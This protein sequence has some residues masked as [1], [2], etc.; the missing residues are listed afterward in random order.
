MRSAAAPVD[1]TDTPA[2][3][4]TAI[5]APQPPCTEEQVGAPTVN[6]RRPWARVF[7]RGGGVGGWPSPA[8][9][10]GRGRRRVPWM[11][12]SVASSSP[13][14]RPGRRPQP[15]PAPCACTRTLRAA[16]TGR[17]RPRPFAGRPGQSDARRMDHCVV[18][19]LPLTRF[20]TRAGAVGVG[21]IPGWRKGATDY[22]EPVLGQEASPGEQTRIR[23]KASGSRRIPG[24]VKPA[25]PWTHRRLYT[26]D[27][28]LIDVR[29]EALPRAASSASP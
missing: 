18:D 7:S 9:E 13:P 4:A 15:S 19:D 27:V 23:K 20:G 16:S 29:A 21:P 10:T 2:R 14:Q 1:A 25:E 26:M 5:C 22:G 12:S 3:P 24:L 17:G 6:R 11:C 28:M 8:G